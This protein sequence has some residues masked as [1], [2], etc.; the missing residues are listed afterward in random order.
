MMISH[1]TVTAQPYP[2]VTVVLLSLG[3]A[4]TLFVGMHP[5]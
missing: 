5:R 4:M 2:V 1:N 3:N